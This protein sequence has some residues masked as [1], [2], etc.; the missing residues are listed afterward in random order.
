M[1]ACPHLTL[2]EPDFSSC[3]EWYQLSFEFLPTHPGL[4]SFHE[5]S[6]SQQLWK[7]TKHNFQDTFLSYQVQALRDWKRQS[8]AQILKTEQN[9]SC[10]SSCWVAVWSASR[11]IASASFCFAF[12]EG[13]TVPIP[14]VCR[15]M[16]VCEVIIVHHMCVTVMH[17]HFVGCLFVERCFSW[18]RLRS[19]WDETLLHFPPHRTR[20]ISRSHHI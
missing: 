20:N 8:Y 19:S 15:C 4:G 1:H 11:L 5:L 10:I 9:V 18:W 14:D 6:G 16:C 7:P 3:K 12:W 13:E 2:C 17:S